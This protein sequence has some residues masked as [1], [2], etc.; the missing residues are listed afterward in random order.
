M[1]KRGRKRKARARKLNGSDLSVDQGR[2]GATRN[3]P[4]LSL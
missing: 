2:T 1:S 4:G 3:G